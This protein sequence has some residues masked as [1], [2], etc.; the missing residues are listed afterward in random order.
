MI[1]YLV[2]SNRVCKMETNFGWPTFDQ[3]SCRLVQEEKK[4][5]DLYDRLHDSVNWEFLFEIMCLVFSI[6]YFSFWFLSYDSSVLINKIVLIFESHVTEN[7][8][9]FEVFSFLIG[10]RWVRFQN[11]QISY[12]VS[13]S[14]ILYFSFQFMSSDR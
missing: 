3:W 1:L 7:Q 10:V 6:F 4:E 11:S 9:K 8:K 12:F 13:F 2:M 5:D 14:T